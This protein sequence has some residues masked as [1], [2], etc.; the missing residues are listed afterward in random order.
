MKITLICFLFV[1]ALSAIASEDIVVADFE[2]KTFGDWKAEGTA[3][4][5]GPAWDT[6]EDQME[7]SGWED[8][9]YVNSFHG[10]DDSKGTLTSPQ[11]N[12]ERDYINFLIGGG[13]FK[14]ETCM[15]L[16]VAGEIVRSATGP[17]TEPGGSELLDWHSWDVKDLK[18]K[19]AQIQIVDNRSGD[20]GHILV[21]HIVQSDQKVEIIENVT[22]EF[23]FNKKYLNLPIKSGTLKRLINVLIDDQLVREFRIRLAPDEPDFWV[24]LELDQFKGKK[25]T[26]RINKLNKN[27]RKGFDSIYQDDTFPGEDEVYKEK[28]RPQFHFSS[29]R[30]WNN[31]P[32]GLMY[33]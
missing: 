22:R 8:Y 23:T 33:Y 30:S 4:G 7:V 5:Q 29:K 16:I 24:Y 15:N 25:A 21:D 17:N 13:G 31:D 26:V 32:N 10:G 28:H 6:L 18:G 2:S 11:F 12:I 9:C 1:F 27:K 19:S 3:F 14:G 20:W